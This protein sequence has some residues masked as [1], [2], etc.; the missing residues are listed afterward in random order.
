MK[1]KLTWLLL[2]CPLIHYGQAAFD[3]ARKGTVAEI[4]KIYSTDKA[5][6]NAVDSNG[7]SM[8]ILACYRG[9]TEVAKYIASKT[10]DI[11]Y[12]NKQGTALMAAVMNGD[13]ALVSYLL[14]KGAKPDIAE[15]SGKTALIYAVS[16]GKTACAKALVSGGANKNIKDN[17]GKTA[18]DYARNT[19]ITELIILLDQ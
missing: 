4:E 7:N 13:A 17:E 10:S 15:E 19:Q 6:V 14:Q 18:L 5:S 1:K 12:K 9:N 16:F 3:I 8:L 2:W 11:N